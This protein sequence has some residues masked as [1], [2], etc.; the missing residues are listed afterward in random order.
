MSRFS[1]LER[2]RAPLRARVDSPVAPTR[3][4]QRGEPGSGWGRSAISR[5]ASLQT[6]HNL[7][8]SRQKKQGPG[9]RCAFALRIGPWYSAMGVGVPYSAID[10]SVNQLIR[11]LSA[12]APV[13]LYRFAVDSGIWPCSPCNALDERQEWIRYG[14]REPFFSPPD[15]SQPPSPWAAA[16]VSYP[17][18]SER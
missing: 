10:E 15:Y 4:A 11:I 13:P 3:C 2:A 14:Y 1:I 17:D 9:S 18:S 16:S 6:I 12:C 8:V 7:S 5:R